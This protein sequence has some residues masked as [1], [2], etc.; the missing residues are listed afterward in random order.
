MINPYKNIKNPL[1]FIWIGNELPKWAK[2]SLELSSKFSK[3]PIILI[4]SKKVGT[5]NGI[6]AHIYTEDFYKRDDQL[7]ANIDPLKSK[8]WDG[9]WIKTTER[10]FVLEQYMKKSGI[11]SAFHAELDNLVFDLT[12][13]AEKLDSIG[14][15]VF[16]PQDSPER[17]IFSLG[18]IND[19]SALGEMRE[20]FTSEE[21]FFSNDMELI[22]A[23]LNRIKKFHALPTEGVLNNK[24]DFLNCHAIEKVGGIFDA[25]SLGQYVF[26]IDPRILNGVLKNRFINEN[27]GCDLNKLKFTINRSNGYMSV[28]DIRG[29]SNVNLYNLHVHSKLFHKLKKFGY[30]EMVLDRLNMGLPT[31]ISFNM[32]RY[33]IWRI[34]RWAKNIKFLMNI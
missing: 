17:G 22:G 26:G 4:S 18:Y 9:F 11:A 24:F 34:G 6:R 31:T 29:N 5:V 27:A 10:F 33:R 16:V 23:A 21:N 3:T 32:G 15:G 25:A 20:L 14:S 1:I 28:G 2:I 12:G 19:V 13:L 7:F 8:F 30:F